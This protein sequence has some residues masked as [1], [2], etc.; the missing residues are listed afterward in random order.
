MAPPVGAFV[1]WDTRRKA[2]STVD[3]RRLL[4]AACGFVVACAREAERQRE[5]GREAEAERG[6]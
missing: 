1:P 3:E 6:R 4:V 5:V 2:N